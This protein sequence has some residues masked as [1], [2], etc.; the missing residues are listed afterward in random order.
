MGVM[1]GAL[2]WEHAGWQDDY[3]PD[4]LPS[5]WRLSYYAND[6][7]AVMLPWESWGDASL[8]DIATW[9]DD[10]HE[11]FRFFLQLG[12]SYDQDRWPELQQRLALFSDQLGGLLLSGDQMQD[13]QAMLL[14]EL[15]VT[16]YQAKKSDFSI[17]HGC[18][19]VAVG[20]SQISS[21]ILLLD[22]GVNSNLRQIRGALEQIAGAGNGE[23][24]TA[25]FFNGKPP[26]VSVMREAS[27]LTE[28]M[29]I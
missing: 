2:G 1:I 3:Y 28:L 26:S 8:K 25:L 18:W 19:Q 21:T 24:L 23:Q 6:F 14:S 4:D 16:C 9:V 12:K 7:P 20:Q 5:D 13:D 10:V 17:A 27:V 11:A 29:G 22:S 15:G